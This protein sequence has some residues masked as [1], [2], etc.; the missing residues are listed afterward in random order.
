MPHV[1]ACNQR[2]I[3]KGRG[4]GSLKRKWRLVRGSDFSL[5]TIWNWLSFFVLRKKFW[6]Q[7]ALGRAVCLHSRLE[8]E[9]EHAA[10]M[11][12]AMTGLRALWAQLWQGE[13]F[14]LFH[15]EAGLVVQS[16]NNEG[17]LLLLLF[18]MPAGVYCT[19]TGMVVLLF[20][21]V[22]TV[23]PWLHA[24]TDLCVSIAIRHS[25]SALLSLSPFKCG[26]CISF[27]APM[28]FPLH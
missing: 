22:C 11:Q 13:A 24:R 25:L 27:C 2:S 5:F 16:A 6:Q 18:L 9:G 14:R 10:G 28:D 19:H 4:K 7:T 17:I 1:A 12:A 23:Y 26:S 15:S 20:T 8:E 3:S 21:S